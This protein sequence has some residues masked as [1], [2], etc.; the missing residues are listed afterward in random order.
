VLIL[1]VIS[2]VLGVTAIHLLSYLLGHEMLEGVLGGNDTLWA[3]SL[4]HWFNRWFPNLPVWFP[5]QAGG[6]P[7]LVFYPPMTSLLAVL[8]QRL[9]GL[10]EVQ[11]LSLVGFISVPIA[12]TGVYLLVWAKLRSQAA[13]LIAGLL[14]PLSAASWYWVTFMGM[15]AQG[16]SLMFFPYAFL[17]F[18]SYITRCLKPPLKPRRLADRLI[19]PL[20]GI[21]LSLTLLAH[22]ATGFVLCMA[23]MLDAIVQAFLHGRGRVLKFVLPA[24]KS[25]VIAIA[26]GL[27]VAAIWFL[28]FV[29][30]LRMANRE[31]LSEFAAH[32][33][34]YTYISGI[35][36]FGE[37]SPS[38]FSAGLTLAPPV[39]VLALCGAV[40]ALLRQRKILPWALISAA[41]MLYTS[42][43]GLWQDIVKVFENLWAF[44]QARAL[45]PAILLVPALAGC[46]AWGVARALVWA[47]G[48]LL[49]Y[50]FPRLAGQSP[51]AR[52]AQVLSAGSTNALAVVVSLTAT[53][54]LDGAFASKNQYSLF[55]PPGG[56]TGIP[57]AT[58]DGAIELAHPPKL[59]I[60][61]TVD[62]GIREMAAILSERLGLDGSVRID[63]SPNLG[64]LT[65]GMGL[66]SD[67]LN[68]SSYNYQS[69]LLHAMW[70][71]QQGLF[72][73]KSDAASAELDELAKWFGLQYVLLHR[74][75]DDLRKFDRDGWP[76][77]YPLQGDGQSVFE[78]RQ[79]TQAPSLASYT[80]GPAILVIGGYENAIYEQVFQT[81]MKA[82]FGFDDAILVE[83]KHEIDAYDIEDLRQFDALMLH[84]YGYKNRNRAWEVLEQY[85]REGGGLYA[86]T[87]WQYWTPDWDLNP[88]P[89]VLPIQSGLWTTPPPGNGYQFN[90][91][92]ITGGIEVQALSPLLWEGAPW[93]VSAPQGQLKDWGR[94][95]L[96]YGEIPLI[97]QG[98]YG[99]GRVVW[100][101][102]NLIGHAATYDNSAE[103]ELI[104]KL[105]DWVAAMDAAPRVQ[106]LAIERADPDHV[107]LSVNRP[108]GGKGYI[109]W[110]EAFSQGWLGSALIDGRRVSLPIYRAGP[111]L[112]LAIVPEA[113]DPNLAVE[114]RY[115]LGLT[116]LGGLV[117]SVTSLAIA[118]F[119]VVRPPHWTPKSGHN[120][121]VRVG[122][123]VRNT[124]D[125]ME[126]VAALTHELVPGSPTADEDHAQHAASIEPLSD[127]IER[128][129]LESWLN[130]SGHS[131]DAWAEK[132]LGRKN[133]SLE[134]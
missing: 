71:Y 11:A 54:A 105:I 116:G 67:A 59:S 6:T 19:L 14:Y 103:R 46:G 77:A 65:Q 115:G 66:Y 121:L 128:A 104:V 89:N 49:R 42:M 120:V 127:E 68:L 4:V 73:G 131:D 80:D 48:K 98:S 30:V 118:V 69:S 111:G 13:A 125:P 83:G 32:Q 101:G 112:V 119:L 74:G 109:L 52:L 21:A 102:M 129:L 3:L 97:V 53:V 64:G 23:V 130:G 133:N 44:T 63:I 79:F 123:H 114:L 94:A 62:P 8:V 85:V 7:L 76:V 51:A 9:T 1:R 92:A 84:G 95:V 72:Y 75:E 25:A 5:L 38:V 39:G 61:T 18:D 93:G 29:S 108:E 56:S 40:Y 45:V 41:F 117:I 87:G 99:E 132:L 17:F 70:G 47:P 35:F 20:A 107:L 134:A 96:S 91:P 58:A 28:P 2:F 81:L 82:G 27:G 122:E 124:P 60:T 86:D 10:T 36:G 34:P 78:V 113:A 12:A 22:G 55:G 100:S 43:P 15:Y 26:L 24:L 33:V 106:D 57:V 90:D 16:V 110:R 88:A 31:G 37:P 50:A 126:P